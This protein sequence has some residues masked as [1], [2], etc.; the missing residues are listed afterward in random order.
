MNIIQHN[1]SAMNAHRTYNITTK[2]NKKSAEKLSSGYRINRSSDDAAGLTISEKM[3]AQIRNLNQGSNNIQSGI[4]YVQVA[5]GALEEVHSML[6]R[7]NELAVQAANDT[8]SDSDR[9]ALDS[10]MQQLKFE[11]DRIFTTTEF[12]TKQIWSEDSIGKTPVKIGTKPVQGV[13]IATD[14]SQ[15]IDLSNASYDK[16]AKNS[17]TINADD[18]G[19]WISW[20]AYNGKNYTTN[21]IDWTTFENNGYRFQVGD[22][23]KTTD[24]EL[25]DSNGN[26]YID[27]AI[28]VT[29]EPEATWE[30]IR[31]AIN[32]TTMSSSSR[33]SIT[34]RFED[35]NGNSATIRPSGVS[36]SSI[37]INFDAA[38]AS[39]KAFPNNSQ[40]G[41]D[42][43]APDD[44]FIEI[45][46]VTAD[47]GNLS[48]IP[49]NN[50][51]DPF[52]AAASNDAWEFVFEVEGIGT[53]RTSPAQIRY[54]AND[55][56]SHSEDLWWEYNTRGNQT[57]IPHTINTASLSSVMDALTGAKGS[58]TPGI[59]SPANGGAAT[60]GGYLFVYFDLVSDSSFTTSS[61]GTSNDVGSLNLYITIDPTDDEQKVLEKINAALNSETR[62]D[63]YTTDI[64]LEYSRQTVYASYAKQALVDRDVFDYILDYGEMN[65]TIQAGQGSNNSILINYDCLRVG[66]LGLNDSNLLTADA[67]QETLSK[68]QFALDTVSEQR[69]RFGAYQNRM[70]AMCNVN[71]NSSE[72]TSAGESRIRDTD[73]ANESLSHTKDAVLSQVSQKMIANANYNQKCLIELLK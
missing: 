62:L 71:N 37:S 36:A 56:D 66:A 17:Y 68:I 55:R 65:L 59:L 15:R 57:A 26:P 1:L 22:Y 29:P 21:K 34:S 46:P 58:D 28:A 52:I 45:K 64:D 73:M 67:A 14:S 18:D 40:E 39:K 43:D 35:A 25:F 69:S 16:V 19:I 8:N 60:E 6:Q 24:S 7:I 44:T 9:E 61:G 48:T 10:E 33:V 70:A 38:Y 72:N 63:V 27:F 32:Q 53:V 4:S 47:G 20:N 13:A 49:G 50:T 11:M 5:D 31:D 41:F 30:D 51:T 23:L 54:Y 42:F 12:N 2:A 3:R